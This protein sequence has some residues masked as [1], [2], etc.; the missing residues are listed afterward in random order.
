MVVTY[1]FPLFQWDSRNDPA[2]VL[3]ASVHLVGRYTCIRWWRR[4]RP[5]LSLPFCSSRGRAI[6]PKADISRHYDY[7]Y[8]SKQYRTQSLSHDCPHLLWHVFD[9]S[10]L[11]FSQTMHNSMDSTWQGL[12]PIDWVMR[13]P[14]F[15]GERVATRTQDEPCHLVLRTKEGALTHFIYDYQYTL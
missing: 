8:T 9:F 3:N 14:S 5:A 6:V 15:R 4:Q 11:P 1:F 13:P 2:I 12:F 10:L 7:G